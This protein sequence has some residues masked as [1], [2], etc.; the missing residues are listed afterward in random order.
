[1]DRS[2]ETSLTPDSL[3]R[4]S[5]ATAEKSFHPMGGAGSY[6]SPLPL[7]IS[8]HPRSPLTCL[9]PEMLLGCLTTTG[10]SIPAF[11]PITSLSGALCPINTAH[12]PQM[13]TLLFSAAPCLASKF[14]L[15][16]ILFFFPAWLFVLLIS[17]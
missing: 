6:C 15:S 2:S 5:D 16:K 14:N 7:K 8:I 4:S 13:Q 9:Y 11:K 1:M 17:V 10:L 12:S 3:P